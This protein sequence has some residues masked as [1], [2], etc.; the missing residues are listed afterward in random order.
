MMIC[1]KSFERFVWLF[2][3]C[4]GNGGFHTSWYWYQQ[5]L[6]WRW[7]DGWPSQLQ[8]GELG[9]IPGW[10]QGI[11]QRQHRLQRQDRAWWKLNWITFWSYRKLPH[12][13]RL[14][15]IS[16]Q[17]LWLTH[18]VFRAKANLSFA[19]QALSFPTLA[20]KCGH[21]P[22][23]LRQWP[24]GLNAWS[25][26]DLVHSKP[27]H[28][29]FFRDTSLIEHNHFLSWWIIMDH[30]FLFSVLV[31]IEACRSEAR[32]CFHRWCRECV[33]RIQC[34]RQQSSTL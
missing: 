2:L 16:D 22:L 1:L 18:V 3:L 15:G 31:L 14:K 25:I 28:F 5:S 21:D 12:M 32:I 24:P 17:F 26:L 27:G 20:V 30:H 13:K 10:V 9:C 11:V 29:S 8:R 6:S 34:I 4:P 19:V 7:C 33:P 23:V